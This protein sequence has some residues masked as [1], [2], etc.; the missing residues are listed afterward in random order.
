MSVRN[1]IFSIMGMISLSQKPN[2]SIIIYTQREIY[3]GELVDSPVNG[4]NILT[5]RF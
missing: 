4:V 2:N 3:Q 5:K 1:K